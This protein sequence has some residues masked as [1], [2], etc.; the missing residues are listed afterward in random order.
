MGCGNG[1]ASRCLADVFSNSKVTGIDLDPSCIEFCQQHNSHERIEYV[2]GDFAQHDTKK[3]DHVFALEILEHIKSEKHINFLDQCLRSLKP[4]GLLFLTTPN[5]PN[6]QDA[7]S[8]HGHIGML[9]KDRAL[10]FYERYKTHIISESFYNADKLDTMDYNQFIIY[11][12]FLSF[13]SGQGKTHFRLV[14]KEK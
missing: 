5:N 13:Q 3:Y 7:T 8:P 12:P 1:H 9:N 11:E 6:E 2:L 14:F 10:I 4:N